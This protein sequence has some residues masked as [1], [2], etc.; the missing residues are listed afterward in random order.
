MKKIEPGAFEKLRFLR[1]GLHAFY[2]LRRN[3][4]A[5][6]TGSTERPVALRL[7]VGQD[8]WHQMSRAEALALAEA[9]TTLAAH[10]LE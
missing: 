8:R 7:P 6:L 1:H 10:D 3:G 2:D 4:H 5:A 9:L